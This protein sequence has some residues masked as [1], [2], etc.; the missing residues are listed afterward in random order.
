MQAGQIIRL[1]ERVGPSRFLL[2]EEGWRALVECASVLPL[3]GMWCDGVEV[4]ALFLEAERPLIASTVPMGGRYLSLSPSYEAA[5]VHERMI[6]DLWGAEAMSARDVS[7]LLDIGFWREISPLGVRPLASDGVG[8]AVGEPALPYL[9]DVERGRGG[10][11]HLHGGYAHRGILQ[12]VRGR[13]PEQALRQI[14]RVTS[15]GFVAHSLA[16]CRAVERALGLGISPR[17][18]HARVVLL[19]VE[20]VS[21][22]LHDVACVARCVGAD[23]LAVHAEQGREELAEMCVA[24]G[25]TRRVTDMVVPGGMRGDP[26]VVGLAR[27]VSGWLEPVLAR[28]GGLSVQAEAGLHRLGR[29]G[30][31][32]A[33]ALA[34]GG[35]TGRASGRGFDARR[36][37][38]GYDLG[39]LAP[40]G[41]LGG[42]C[43][44]RLSLRLREMENAA[45]LLEGFSEVFDVAPLE[46]G[47]GVGE[48]VGFAE[49]ARGDVWYWVRLREGVIEAAWGRDP[50]V[51]LWAVLPEM[52]RGLDEAG[53]ATVLASVGMS[54]AGMEF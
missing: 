4:H 49:G 20:R 39:V 3:L 21:V 12:R 30:V 22:H 35:V 14:G 31:E 33:S 52:V 18:E 48:G 26:D 16:F 34:V 2:D 38:P 6:Q 54:M 28:L 42:D 13:T 17:V 10:R 45:V 37:S 5:V 15:G 46:A 32:R 50:A 19:E 47:G 43:W 27:E 41:V 44:A 1:G 24:F 40:R 11:V 8:Q 9:L 7:P 36:L 29:L 23:L 25:V 53:C 51:A